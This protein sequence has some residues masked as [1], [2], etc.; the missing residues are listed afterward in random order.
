[1]SLTSE[2]IKEFID[3]IKFRSTYDFSDYSVKSFCRRVERVLIDNKMEFPL[4]V[5][6]IRRN[7]TFLEKVV[8]DITVNTTE[9]FRD[10]PI[11]HV[12]KFRILPKLAHKNRINIMHTGCSTGQELYSMLILLNELGLF[13]KANIFGTDINEDVLE[14]ARKGVYKYRHNIDYTD[15]FNKVLRENPYNYEEFYDVSYSK[16]FDID[17]IKD[18][19]KMKPFL[20]KKPIFKK[21]NLVTGE[22]VFDTQYDIILCR[23]V[24]IYFNSNLQNKTFENF[25]KWLFRSGVLVLGAHESML[26]PMVNK[27]TKKG[28]YY[29]KKDM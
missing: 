1:M 10:P 25:Y 2:Q 7:K 22:N 23:N 27:F 6:E 5:K 16:Y 21:Q 3:T 20:T 24:L 9:L 29:I 18:T 17:K 28:K 19:I 13:D 8:K 11:W 12:I 26:G 15:N 14:V 4:L